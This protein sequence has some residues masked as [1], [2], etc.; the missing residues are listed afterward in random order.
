[1]RWLFLL[2]LA[3][4]FAPQPVPGAPCAAD[5]TCPSGL[6]CTVNRCELPGAVAD[7]SSD[8]ADAPDDP[9]D[10]MTDAM[11]DAPAIDALMDASPPLPQLVQQATAFLR[12]GTAVTA[13]FPATPTA[14]NILIAVAGC[15]SASLASITGGAPTWQRAAA[16]LI[17]SNIE[18]FIGVANGEKNVSISLPTCANQMSLSISEWSQLATMPVDQTE[19][20]DGIVSPAT[21]GT[22]TTTGAPR[23]I[24]F[25]V[26]N[27]T[28][29]TY[30]T[31]SD[32]PWLQLT[33]VSD[34]V[35]LRTWYRVVTTTGSFAPTVTE[36]N[37]HW[38]ATL[39]ALKPL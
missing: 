20:E 31:P 27:Y 1:M 33:P 10:A 28:P 7:A 2:G 39:V 21:A 16:S 14:G 34:F 29:N 15:P 9:L 11:I 35:E 4:C 37:H 3:G 6:V 19:S 38:D 23:L 13:S 30:G 25:S 26:S 17:N 18:V 12:P 24:L 8:A 32:G 22:V 36:T 5:G